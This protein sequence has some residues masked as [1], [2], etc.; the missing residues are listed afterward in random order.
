MDPVS[1]CLAPLQHGDSLPMVALLS[2]FDGSGFGRV[3]VADALTFSCRQHCLVASAFA[4]EYDDT[5]ASAVAAYWQRR[6]SFTQQPPHT[7][8]AKD[9]WDLLRGAPPHRSRPS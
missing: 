4:A 8:I 6:S 9:V 1:I 5:L 3:A 2:L 7:R